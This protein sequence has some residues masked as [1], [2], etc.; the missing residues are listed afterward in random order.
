MFKERLKKISTKIFYIIFAIL[1]SATL[2]I[3]VEITENEVQRTDIPNIEVVL[4]HVDILRDRGLLI[5]SY[6]PEQ[7]SLTF[8][9][10]RSDINRL[11][12]P[13]ALTVEVDLAN[14]TSAGT[15]RLVYDINFPTGV[16]VG[17]DAIVGRSDSRIT[18]VIDRLLHRQIPVK[19]TYTGGTASGEFVAE[20]AEWDPQTL[21]VWG[22]EEIISRIDYARV[23]ILRENL[24]T[25][26]TEEMEFILI[27]ENGEELSDELRS[28]VEFSQETILVT[29]PIKQIKDVVLIVELFHGESTSDANTQWYV[30]PREIKISG[31][32]EAIRDFNTI[33]LGTIDMMR[34]GLTTTEAF[35]I[36]IPN[37]I[38]NVSGETEALV[39]VDVFGLDIAFRSATNFQTINVPA[40]YTAEVLTQS[41]DVRMRGT[42]EDLALV[43]PINIRIIADLSDMNPGTA[44]VPAKIIIDGID[45]DIDPVGEYEIT[46][47]IAAEQN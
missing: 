8:E 4:R 34:F 5:S 18:I 2:W 44:R 37:H 35:P 11:A 24:S 30:E 14:I 33:R 16:S 29:I 10:A 42:S 41:L 39:H 25:T 28:L 27:E 32:P 17:T 9:A 47:T 22:P 45:A 38:T 40:G 6:E 23:P 21:T 13:G 7:I 12:A 20:A 15:Q 31:D 1:V 26:L 46:V 19:V 36:S 43:T 3:Y